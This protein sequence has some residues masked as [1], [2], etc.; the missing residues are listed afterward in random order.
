[1]IHDTCQAN[2]EECFL[3]SVALP[4][5]PKVPEV[6]QRSLQ[7]PNDSRKLDLLLEN[8]ETIRRTNHNLR[9]IAELVRS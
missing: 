8:G 2:T 9:E 5:G 6:S 3:F 1:M 7:G 4:D